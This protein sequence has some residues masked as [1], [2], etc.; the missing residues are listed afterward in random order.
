MSLFALFVA[1]GGRKRGNR[2]T[3]RQTDRHTDEPSTVTLAAHACRGLITI[4][5]THMRHK[6][7]MQVGEKFVCDF[8]SV[9][10]SGRFDGICIYTCRHV[11][12]INIIICTHSIKSTLFVN[13]TS[14]HVHA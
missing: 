3:D 7:R 6:L 1:R 8:T 12:L 11:F 10:L 2:Q 9:L 14:Q 13:Y 4:F 5:L